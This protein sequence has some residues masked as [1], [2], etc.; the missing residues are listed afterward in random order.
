MIG[1]GVRGRNGSGKDRDMVEAGEELSEVESR[2]NW[3]RGRDK[4]PWDLI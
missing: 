3:D 2:S 1:L 4:H